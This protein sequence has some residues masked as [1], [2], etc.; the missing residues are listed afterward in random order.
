MSRVNLGRVVDYGVLEEA[1]IIAAEELG[2]DVKVQDEFREDYELG[3]VQKVYIYERTNVSLKVL[4]LPA[5]KVR[6]YGKGPTSDFYVLR[7]FPHGFASE[8]RVQEYLN[9]VSR[10]LV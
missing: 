4:M 2:W 7:G 10:N 1:L 9:A 6:V 5:M 8:R 3:S